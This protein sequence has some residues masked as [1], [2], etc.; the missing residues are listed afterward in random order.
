MK[1]TAT[2]SKVIALVLNVIAMG[3]G[4]IYLGN[5]KKAL[6]SFFLIPLTILSFFF[7]STVISLGYLVIL[8]YVILLFIYLYV[9]YDVLVIIKNVNSKYLRSYSKKHIFLFIFLGY[10]LNLLIYEFNPLKLYQI[11]SPSMS[12]TLEIND[13]IIVNKLD[14]DIKRGKLIVFK[15]PNDLSTEYIKRV[16]ALSGDILF[17]KNKSLFLHLREGNAFIKEHYPSNLIH[18]FKGKFFIKNPYKN[19]YVGIHNDKSVQNDGL[20]LIELFTFDEIKIKANHYFVMG[21]NRDHSNDSRFWGS[22]PNKNT[23]GSPESILINYNKLNRTG[24]KII[25]K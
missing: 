21:D 13:N 3:S 8:M 2:K 11:S 20:Q 9:F 17:I 22:V 19:K 18:V 15:Y 6:F 16:V 4:Y 12:N 24:K 1:A 5:L 10:A 25:T 23:V 7:F 14:K